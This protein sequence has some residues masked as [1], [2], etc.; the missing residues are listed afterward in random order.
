[1]IDFNINNVF[2]NTRNSY[3]YYWWW[4]IIDICR[5]KK[6][7]DVHF[8]EIIIKIISKVWYPVNYY[9][10]SFGKIDQC[11]KLVKEIKS[12]YNLEDNIKEQDLY[13]FLIQHRDSEFIIKITNELTRYVPYRFIRPWYSAETRGL[14]DSIVNSEILKL[15]NGRAPYIIEPNSKKISINKE[16]LQWI[17]SNY[18]LIKAYTLFKLIRYLERENP[19]TVNLSKKLEKPTTR[20]LIAPT[21][22]WNK[23]IDYDPNQIDVFERRPLSSIEDFSLDHFL[24]WS[25]FTH[26]LLW[27]LHPVD[28]KINSS[29]SNFI[30]KRKYFHRFYSLQFKFCKFLLD[31][32][33]DNALE[34]YYNLFNCSNDDLQNLSK[35][36]F[37]LEMNKFYMPQYEIARNMGFEDNWRLN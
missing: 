33:N 29:K 36:K 22:Y 20:S 18:T 1:M 4:S 8:D 26:D 23:F 35:E 37:I 16:W 28:K 7:I 12:K 30:P 34:H 11:S 9:K 17:C 24:P 10:L 25:F 14:K 15:Q 2:S 21:K 31:V 6:V 13:K 5:E 32:Q 19:N 27:N 3:K